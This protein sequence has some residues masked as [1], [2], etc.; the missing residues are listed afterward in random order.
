MR[1]FIT[2]AH[3]SLAKVRELVE[4]LTAG[5]HDVWFD[6]Q[7]LP[8]Q[9]WKRELGDAIARCEAFVYALTSDAVQSEWCDWEFA[10]AARLHK[11]VI[12]VL[13]EPGVAIPTP[14]QSLQYADFTNGATP[15]S[16]AKLLGAFASM[17]QVPVNQSPPIPSDPKGVPARAWESVKHWT[18]TFIT[19]VHK[20]QNEAEEIRGKFGASVY[21]GAE[22]VGGRL[23]ITNQRLLFE[24]HALNINREPV[25][26]PLRDITSVTTVRSGI[27]PNGI[28]VS[29]FSGRRYHFVVWG[30]KR[31]IA[32]IEQQRA[33][34]K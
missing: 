9:D 25:D 12:P 29:C 27:L 33:S 18:D 22:V 28:L 30:R 13:M 26:I 14:L 34:L 5:G 2:Y 17:R 8:G 21:Q 6:H 20:Q 11:P 16:V 4:I 15:V 23:I 10:T 31:I 19:P 7:L 3:E 32:M 1:L 24:A